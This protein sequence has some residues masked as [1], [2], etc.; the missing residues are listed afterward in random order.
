MHNDYSLTY[1]DLLEIDNSVTIHVRNLQL[2]LTEIYNLNPKEKFI[3]ENTHFNLRDSKSLRVPRV[4]T[5]IHELESIS[6][7][8]SQ[9]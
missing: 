2:L 9:I 5:P 3:R 1:N 7:R 4:V 6:F 8:G